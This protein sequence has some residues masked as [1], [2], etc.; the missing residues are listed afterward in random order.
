M[1][2]NKLNKLTSSKMFTLTVVLVVILI[3]FTVATKGAM[4]KLRNIRSIL[5]SITVVS[6]LSIGAGLLLISGNTDLSLAA[7]GTLGPMV[8]AFL[9][10]LG[11]PWWL[12]LIAG[13]V[14]SAI[15]GAINATMVNVFK[16]PTFIATL[17]MASVAKG[18]A[19]TI[20]AGKNIDIDNPVLTFIGTER[21]LEYIPYSVFIAVIALVI[22]GI[23]L[24]RSKFGRSIY[25]IGG[26][27]EAA[28]LA[29]IK[30][31]KISYILFINASC[32]ACIAGTLMSSRIKTATCEGISA[33]QFTGL[34]AAI[35]G[36]IS[37]GGGSGGIGG[38]V[39][40]ILILNIF[41]NGMQM[42]GVPSYWQTVSSGVLLLAAL[43]YDHWA[44]RRRAM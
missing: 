7:I 27:P 1:N 11:L 35:L 24:K 31:K 6:F 28:R 39:I 25:L 44:A 4:L 5:Q 10:T 3:F 40:G 16:F 9:L 19:Y 42:M 29:G 23:M 2:K 37:F 22:Y 18:I 33:Q 15:C 34:T 36:G 41:E 32:L 43:L 14:V 38:A 12:A 13:L 17:A 8:L 26:N 30:P 21:L 20:S